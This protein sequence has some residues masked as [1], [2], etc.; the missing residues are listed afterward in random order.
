MTKWIHLNG[1]DEAIK[2]TFQRALRALKAGGLF[3]LEPQPFA[4]Y[5]RKRRLNDQIAV[6]YASI[7]LPPEQFP[8]YLLHELRIDECTRFVL[9]GEGKLRDSEA[10]TK[11][12]IRPLYIFQKVD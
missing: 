8:R 5:K 11:G 7:R 2:R 3:L 6:N 9:L 12:F 4:S 10:Q 1:G